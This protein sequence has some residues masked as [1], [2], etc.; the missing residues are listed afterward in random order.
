MYVSSVLRTLYEKNLVWG[1]YYEP[2]KDPK[3]CLGEFN[4]F[5]KIFLKVALKH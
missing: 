5:L 4:S 1:R 2:F 3:D